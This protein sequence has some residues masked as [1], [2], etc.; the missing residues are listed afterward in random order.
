MINERINHARAILDQHRRDLQARQPEERIEETG[1]RHNPLKRRPRPKTHFE[2]PVNCLQPTPLILKKISKIM[3]YL[4][5]PQNIG[6]YNQIS[7]Q[8]IFYQEVNNGIIC[9]RFT[10]A[11]FKQ[12][13][14]DDVRTNDQGHP[15][16]PHMHNDWDF[17]GVNNPISNLKSKYTYC[18][19]RKNGVTIFRR[20][21][22]NGRE[23]IYHQ[24][25]F[26]KYLQDLLCL[27]LRY[28][29]ASNIVEINPQYACFVVQEREFAD[30]EQVRMVDEA[31]EANVQLQERRARLRE[32]Y[33][34]RYEAQREAREQRRRYEDLYEQEFGMRMDDFN[35]AAMA[36]EDALEEDL[37]EFQPD[38]E[39]LDGLQREGGG[40]ILP[41]QGQPP[42]VAPG[43]GFAK[44]FWLYEKRSR[45][46]VKRLKDPNLS[47]QVSHNLL[48]DVYS[49]SKHEIGLGVA[50][51]QLMDSMVYLDFRRSQLLKGKVGEENRHQQD[52]GQVVDKV[53]DYYYFRKYFFG[54][55]IQNFPL[56]F[57][58][59]NQN[60]DS[61][62]YGKIRY[63]VPWEYQGQIYYVVLYKQKY[64]IFVM[65]SNFEKMWSTLE[66]FKGDEKYSDESWQGVYDGVLYFS[67]V[68]PQIKNCL[69]YVRMDDLIQLALDKFNKKNK[70]KGK[71]GGSM[72]NKFIF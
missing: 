11:D 42:A 6:K 20:G 2:D 33:Q 8:A 27:K 23:L 62:F 61:F 26:G 22:F 14:V 52:F 67:P 24:R 54:S 58:K 15:A 71:G 44:K 21:K 25:A 53:G 48:F 69:Y 51:P 12:K 3:N 7:N 4:E 57:K 35:E 17:N 68:D 55:K 31:Q 19:D 9:Y 64:G 32:A 60:F 28:D 65:N 18:T 41:P 49:P 47:A 72:F 36:E 50:K 30:L 10:N 45:K 70:G 39:I 13:R 1:I 40:V 5:F 66:I 59:F 63:S 34:E 46:V 38:Q 29:S 16:H 56:F 37:D 43:V